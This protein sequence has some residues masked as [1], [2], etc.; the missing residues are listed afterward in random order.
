VDGI[1]DFVDNCPGA[2]NPSQSNAD[3]DGLGDKCD[4][5]TD[6]DGDGFG[7]PGFAA[8]TC[9]TDNCPTISNTGQEDAD[10]LSDRGQYGPARRGHGRRRRYL[11]QLRR[12]SEYQPG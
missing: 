8:N 11:R 3:D 9:N 12:R 7:D 6:T 5:C 10:Q 1:C 4:D 2:A